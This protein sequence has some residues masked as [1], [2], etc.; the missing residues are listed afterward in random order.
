MKRNVECP[1]SCGKK[2]EAILGIKTDI[3][4]AVCYISIPSIV[5]S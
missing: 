1:A 3:G 2:A 5:V 4:T